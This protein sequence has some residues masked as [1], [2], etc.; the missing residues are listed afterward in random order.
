MKQF[1]W[2]I[3]LV[4]VSNVFILQVAIVCSV[5]QQA[6]SNL[7][8][9]AGCG[10]SIQVSG[11]NHFYDRVLVASIK[12]CPALAEYARAVRTLLN[13]FIADNYEFNPHVTI[14]KLTREN[15]RAVGSD[16]VPRWLYS[17]FKN[18][19]FGKQPV[20]TI[21]LCAMSHHIERPGGEF[22][23]TPLHMDLL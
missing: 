15:D 14:L 4:N 11:V 22:Y 17:E 1:Y 18:K 3:Y 7:S 19:Y 10:I 6:K 8:T 5:L 20:S 9:L 21:D 2:S 23:V 12:Q 16:K 13:S